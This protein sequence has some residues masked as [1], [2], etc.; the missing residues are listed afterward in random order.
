[1][2]EKQIKEF[3]VPIYNGQTGT[4]VKILDANSIVVEIDNGNTVIIT[5]DELKELTLGYCIS[6]YKSQGST[7]PYTIS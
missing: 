5:K 2:T 7:I 3:S 4:V 6:L 1:M